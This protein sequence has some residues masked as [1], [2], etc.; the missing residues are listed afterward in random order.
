V[1]FP[2]P[3]AAR[4]PVRTLSP[5]RQERGEAAPDNRQQ[6]LPVPAPVGGELPLARRE[7]LLLFLGI[8]IACAVIAIVDRNTSTMDAKSPRWFST[9]PS[10]PV[11]RPR[12]VSQGEALATGILLSHRG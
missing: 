11:L 9:G 2:S 10:G 4:Q 12:P 1:K 7:R 8:H 6:D 5:G 3:R